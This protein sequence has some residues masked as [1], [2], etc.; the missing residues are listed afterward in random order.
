MKIIKN[1]RNKIIRHDKMFLPLLRYSNRD[2]KDIL[3][4][5]DK[6]FPVIPK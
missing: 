1:L 3:K 2:D 4:L 6:L 5:L